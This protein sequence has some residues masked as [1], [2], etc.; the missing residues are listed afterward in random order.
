MSGKENNKKEEEKD[1]KEK[2]ELKEEKRDNLVFGA[3]LK[4]V[5]FFLI[6][7]FIL[8]GF[9][10]F[11]GKEVIDLR[12][13]V[14]KESSLY[15]SKVEFKNLGQLVTQSANVTVVKNYKNSREF[16]KLFDI[17]FTEYVLIFSY[18]VSVDAYIDFEKVHYTKNDDEKKFYVEIPHAKSK[19]PVLDEGSIR[20]LY[21]NKNIFNSVDF[22]KSNELRIEV[23]NKG[24]EEALKQGLLD[25]AEKNAELLIS[26]MLKTD[27]Q[28]K[29]YDV[30]FNYI[31]G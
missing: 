20:T 14:E 27:E 4:H 29:N 21:D 11:L 22:D 28:C 31:G 24:L 19:D 10:I 1:W 23:K 25:K 17:P 13:K 5:V 8:I 30:E 12:K 3:Y 26:N 16:L 2:K 7:I 18:D 6:V 9:I 15:V